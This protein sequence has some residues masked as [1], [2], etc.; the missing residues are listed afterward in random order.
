[1]PDI[2]LGPVDTHD[3]G[4]CLVQEKEGFL[5]FTL[6]VISAIA[7]AVPTARLECSTPGDSALTEPV[8][9]LSSKV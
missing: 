5:K 1:V 6:S 9:P 7:T 8:S 3:K 2:V 4:A